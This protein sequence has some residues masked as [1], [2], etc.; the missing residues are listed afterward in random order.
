MIL[1]TVSFF[2]QLLNGLDES[3]AAYHVYVVIMPSLCRSNTLLG[4]A[5]VAAC[6]VH[7]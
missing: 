6:D 3:Q 7:L 4:E 2:K 1:P 5:L